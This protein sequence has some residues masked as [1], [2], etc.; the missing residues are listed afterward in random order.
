MAIRERLTFLEGDGLEVMRGHADEESEAFFIDPPYTA[1]G[2][3]AGSRLYSKFDLDHEELFAIAS[4]L[5]GDFLMTYDDAEGVRA[6]AHRHGFATCTVAM[7]NTHHAKMRELL[8]GRDLSWV[9]RD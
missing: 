9:D 8:I 2:K 1:A 5:R 3:K 7:K 6:L 4:T